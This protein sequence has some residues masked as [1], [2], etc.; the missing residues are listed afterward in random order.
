[1]KVFLALFVAFQVRSQSNRFGNESSWD[2]SI[3]SLELRV[4]HTHFMSSFD[5][6]GLR[7]LLDVEFSLQYLVS[8]VSNEVNSLG[9][10]ECSLYFLHKVDP[11][12]VFGK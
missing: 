3:F 10:C 2:C 4:V 5:P 7:V 1:L 11:L 12:A 8:W 9:L 6:A